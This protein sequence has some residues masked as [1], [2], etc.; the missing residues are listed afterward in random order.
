MMITLIVLIT[1][2]ILWY[3]SLVKSYCND[4]K[5]NEL[6][7][8][9]KL[10]S[11]YVAL[12]FP[13]FSFY[14]HLRGAIHCFKEKEYKSGFKFLL[15]TT[16]FSSTGIALLNEFIISVL[17]NEAVYKRDLKGNKIMTKSEVKSK[18]KENIKNIFKVGKSSNYANVIPAI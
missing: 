15:L 11:I 8:N 7:I 16:I 4:R 18:E 1:F 9:A 13:L 12:V 2:A 3:S 14:V 5:N 6:P 10:S 17:V